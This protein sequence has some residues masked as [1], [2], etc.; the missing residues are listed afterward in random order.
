MWA[1]SF[2]HTKSNNKKTPKLRE[3]AFQRAEEELE[4][5]SV[6]Q[7]E[8]LEILQYKALLYAVRKDTPNAQKTLDRMSKKDFKIG[9]RF[10]YDLST[11]KDT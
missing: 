3:E 7:S 11:E 10:G 4:K 5:E 1:I 2:S 9:L 8:M 6:M